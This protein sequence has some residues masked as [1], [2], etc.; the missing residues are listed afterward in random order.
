M[1]AITTFATDPAILLRRVLVVDAITCTAMG[2]A[3]LAAA[4]PLSALL[5][6]PAGLLQYAGLGLLPIAAF[7]G[8]IATRRGVYSPGVRVVIAGNV[9]WALASLAL[10][11]SAWVSP[12][13]LGE[14]FIV[15]QAAA[16]VVLAV[17]EGIALH[18]T[19]A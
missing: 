10:V 7:V 4:T 8:W 3:L 12:N 18:R 6:L 11:A 14:A 17:L 9:L 5:N 19:S 13:L 16:V 15:L 2:V 1:S